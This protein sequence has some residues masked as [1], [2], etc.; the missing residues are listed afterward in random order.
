MTL[1]LGW[2]QLRH[3]PLRLLVAL[4]G[5]GFAVLLIMMQLGF[6]AALFESGA[7][8]LVY[9][10]IGRKTAAPILVTHHLLLSATR[11]ETTGQFRPARILV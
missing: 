8:T 7:F 10:E 5:I 1:P 2:L 11:C 3:R 9:L 4:A 6:R